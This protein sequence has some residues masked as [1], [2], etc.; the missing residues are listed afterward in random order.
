VIEYADVIRLLDDPDRKT[1]KPGPGKFQ[2][3]EDERIASGVY[4][5]S[6]DSSNMDDQLGSV[7]EGMWIGW[8][9]RF[10]MWQDPD[11]F[12]EYEAFASNE[13][14]KHSFLG[15]GDEDEDDAGDFTQGF[16]PEQ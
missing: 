13:D 12:F 16:I 10:V 5:L 3:C 1:A 9:G 6:L 8:M 15:H 7:E 2:T 14:A 4:E 11:G